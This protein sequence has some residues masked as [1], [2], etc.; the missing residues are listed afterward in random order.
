MKK[1]LCLLLALTLALG[2][3]GGAAAS[4]ERA[5]V[6]FGSFEQ[7][8]PGEPISWIVLASSKTTTVLLSEYCLDCRKFDRENISVWKNSRLRKWLNDTFLYDAFTREERDALVANQDGDYVTIPTLGDMLNEDFGFINNKNAADE[9]RSATGTPYAINQGLWLNRQ[10]LCSYYTR[11]A[12]YDGV[13]CQVRT[14]GTIGSAR[15]DRDNVGIRMVIYVE[16]DVLQ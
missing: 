5:R 3:C 13:L 15:A 2:L 16:T 7:S 11:T 12:S 9:A 6:E 1:G 8:Y 10:G 14:D 4:T